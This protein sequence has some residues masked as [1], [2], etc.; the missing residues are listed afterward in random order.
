MRRY[1]D[2]VEENPQWVRCMTC[3]LE[4]HQ[5]REKVWPAGRECVKCHCLEYYQE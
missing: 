4:G 2:V 5:W 3:A 1:G